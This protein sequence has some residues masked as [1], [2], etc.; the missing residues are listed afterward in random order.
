MMKWF[1][2][3]Q[4]LDKEASRELIANSR[5]PSFFPF[6]LLQLL[7][8][9][10]YIGNPILSAGAPGAW[11]AGGARRAHLVYDLN[12]VA[13][14]RVKVVY[15]GV[16]GAGAMRGGL[17]MGSDIFSLVKYAGNPLW[18]AAPD[19]GDWAYEFELHQVP[20]NEWRLYYAVRNSLSGTYSIYRRSGTDLF[21]LSR[22]GEVLSASPPLNGELTIAHPTAYYDRISGIT[23]MLFMGYPQ[24]IG[25]ASGVSTHGWVGLADDYPEK[26]GKTFHKRKVVIE[27]WQDPSVNIYDIAVIPY[28]LAKIGDLFVLPCVIRNC[29]TYSYE[30]TV[31]VSTNLND[32]FIYPRRILTRSEAYEKTDA[33]ELQQIIPARDKY[34]ILYDYINTTSGL[35]ELA[36]VISPADS[37][38]GEATILEEATLAAGATTTL[39]DCRAIELADV[40]RLAITVEATYDAA[41]AAGIKVHVRTSYDGT[42]YDTE[43]WDTWTPTGFAA[44]ATIRQTKQYDTDPRFVKVLIE[45]LD[46]GKAVTDL[47]VIATVERRV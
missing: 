17:A 45:N 44:G 21:N 5:S 27:E 23:Y 34:H 12:A 47:K 15:T 14:Q 46:A 16:D 32:W 13:A 1:R 19:G 25:G 7:N 9:F 10:K 37:F 36:L 18:D 20:V 11:D 24:R 40:E 22:D 33:T 30:S 28:H 43:D 6:P 4:E 38:K 35:Y 3:T 31:F 26:D 39:A 8:N 41:A 2:D 29:Y 42:N